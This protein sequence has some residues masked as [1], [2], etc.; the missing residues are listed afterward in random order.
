MFCNWVYAHYA[1]GKRVMEKKRVIKFLETQMRKIIYSEVDENLSMGTSWYLL[2]RVEN[3][4]P[5]KNL[6]RNDH[7]SFIHN[8]QN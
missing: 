7:S 6:H 8:C 5:H 1:I 3:L 4:C 2:K